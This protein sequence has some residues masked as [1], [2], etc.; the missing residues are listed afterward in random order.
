MKPSMT[1]S[2][3]VSGI[4]N[5]TPIIRN[6]GEV[7]NVVVNCAREF[8]RAFDENPCNPTLRT[9][10]AAVGC[11]RNAVKR[12][13]REAQKSN[14]LALTLHLPK[15]K[16]LS[17]NLAEKYGLAEAVVSLTPANWG[18]PD[19]VRAALAPEVM[20]Y[21]ERA[22][23]GLAELKG[24]QSTVRI[25]VDGGLTL[26]QA[27]RDTTTHQFPT[28]LKYELVPLTFGPL[29]GSK[30]TATVVANL[31]ASR[32]ETLGLGVQVQDAFA[33]KTEALRIG[34]RVRDSRKVHFTIEIP[35]R[36]AVSRLD[37]F[38]A[39]IGS[40]RAGSFRHELRLSRVKGRATQ[41]HIGDI[42]CLPFNHDGDPVESLSWGQKT[43]LNLG[44]LQKLASSP[45]ALVIG[46]AGGIDKI[47]AIRIILK[48]RYIS[49]LI[50]DPETALALINT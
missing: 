45:T 27:V 9:I 3:T 38:V 35:D 29:E 22:C 14:L 36:A 37:I 33:V 39:G 44:E 13:L 20:R 19:S 25:G 34:G 40:H 31:L 32:L 6:S 7:D 26:Y 21:L 23:I 11:S 48:R 4:R 1:A 43:L 24:Q 15:E 30:Y 8:A 16:T 41:E 49:V 10:A 18:D 50:T 46:A 17:R 28:K 47:D 5:L 42:T 2:E 12:Y